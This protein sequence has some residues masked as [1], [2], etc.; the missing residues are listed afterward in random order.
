V[1]RRTIVK[2]C[3]ITRLEDATLALDLGADWVGLVLWPGS[4]RALDPADAGRIAAALRPGVAVAVVVTAD[5]E[6]ALELARRAGAARL[7]VHRADP[8]R[9]PNEAELPLCF[10]V[11]VGADGQI[12]APVPDPRHLLMLDTADER[13]PGGTGRTFPWNAA[14][15]LAAARPVM[16]SGGL[17]ADN[18][19]QALERVRPWGVD[20]SS[21]LESAPGIKDPLA[22]R[23]FIEAVRAWDARRARAHA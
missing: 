21:R 3:G 19:E 11:P 22:L 16:L 8:A 12:A 7:Q 18:V 23:R 17:D 4:P 14:A 6:E 15:A 20:A 2:I 13:M 10:S 5:P 9:W 1:I